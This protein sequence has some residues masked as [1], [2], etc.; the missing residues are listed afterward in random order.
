[1]TFAEDPCWT[2]VK[3]LTFTPGMPATLAD[4][5]V[6]EFAWSKRSTTGTP[7]VLEMS[8]ASSTLNTESTS[9]PSA[10][11]SRPMNCNEMRTEAPPRQES[12][13]R[14]GVQSEARNVPAENVHVPSGQTVQPL[15]PKSEA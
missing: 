11:K 8:L 12:D 13:P 6:E 4:S 5:N 15:E 9:A 7:I 3:T 2:V 1:M 10:S 14:H